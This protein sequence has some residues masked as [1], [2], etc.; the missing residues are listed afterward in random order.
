MTTSLVEG[1][2]GFLE[3]SGEVV[4]VLWELHEGVDEEVGTMFRVRFDDGVETDA[5]EDELEPL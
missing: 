1:Y 5:F 2:P 3:R 4:E